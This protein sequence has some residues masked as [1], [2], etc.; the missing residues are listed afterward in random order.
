MEASEAAGAAVFDV[1]AVHKALDAAE[2]AY[3]GLFNG[4]VADE[5]ARFDAFLSTVR[6]IADQSADR[7]SKGE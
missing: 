3:H 6:M 5:V 7:A 1:S 4:R 2:K